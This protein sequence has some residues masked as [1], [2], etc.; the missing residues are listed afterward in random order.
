MVVVLDPTGDDLL[1]FPRTVVMLQLH[2]S[3]VSGQ[4]VVV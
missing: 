1:Q 4:G 2:H 3:E